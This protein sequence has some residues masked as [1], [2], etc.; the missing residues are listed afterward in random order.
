MFIYNGPSPA[1]ELNPIRQ[2]P[3]DYAEFEKYRKKTCKG[4]LKPM[5]QR[6]TEECS[7]SPLWRAREERDPE[8]WSKF[9]PEGIR[10][11]GAKAWRIHIPK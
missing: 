7:S 4:Q 1:N 2:E 11:S 8:Y 3:F 10:L 9:S 6:C 5:T